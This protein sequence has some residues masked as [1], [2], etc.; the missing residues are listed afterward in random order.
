MVCLFCRGKFVCGSPQELTEALWTLGSAGVSY[1][2]PDQTLL[3]EAWVWQWEE[4]TDSVWESEEVQVVTFGKCFLNTCACITPVVEP[5][6]I[7]MLTHSLF[8][9]NSDSSATPDCVHAH[10][11][12]TVLQLNKI[13]L[14][15]SGLA[16]SHLAKL[17]HFL[18]L[19]WWYFSTKQWTSWH[20][21]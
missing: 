11:P 5:C 9:V 6:D 10:L 16:S 17:T 13:L 18:P 2:W 21:I 1:T 7:V 14:I 15:L 20:P 8:L 12:D 3:P 19:L 4:C